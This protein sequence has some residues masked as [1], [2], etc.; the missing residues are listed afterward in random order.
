MTY[1][2]E[3]LVA[4]MGAAILAHTAGIEFSIE[5]TA[6]YIDHWRN[7]ITEDEKLVISAASR[8]HKAAEFILGN[9]KED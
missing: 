2:D 4:E 8:G 5:N 6:A 7:K 9:L 1:A 3:E